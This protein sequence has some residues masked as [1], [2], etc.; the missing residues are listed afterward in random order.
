MKIAEKLNLN[1]EIAYVPVAK[2]KYVKKMMSDWKFNN[3]N[4][5]IYSF[6][7]MVTSFI[8]AVYF[9][10]EEEQ[11][12]MRISFLTSL[13]FLLTGILVTKS[14]KVLYYLPMLGLVTFSLVPAY[15]PMGTIRIFFMITVLL[16]SVVCAFYCY[17]ALYN[18]KNVYLPLS[19]RQGFPNFVLS[20]ADMYSD[21]MYEKN[22]DD[23][24]VAEKRVEA[25]YNPFSE[26]SDITDEEVARMN[27]LRYEEVKHYVKDVFRG[28]YYESKEVQYS[29]NEEKTYKYGKKI[30]CKDFIIP[31][32]EIEGAKK[33]DNRKVMWYWNE[34]KKSMFQ[35]EVIWLFLFAASIMAYAWTV[36]ELKGLLMYVFLALH[37]LGTSLV[38]KED[39]RGFPLVL[40]IYLNAT[41]DTFMS[42]I[43]VVLFTIIKIPGYIRWLCN[44]K[45]YRKLEK[46]PGFPSFVENTAD[47]YG[48]Q[49]YIVEKQEPP[50]K[51]PKMEPIIMNVGYDEEE[52]KDK[53]WNAFDYLDKDKDNSAYDD[54]EY[55]EQ[56]YE[57]RRKAEVRENQKPNKDMGR[58]TNNED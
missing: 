22:K 52:K 18:Y 57:A 17:K 1:M 27:S 24:T 9:M 20:T 29:V 48:E 15:F 2:L 55:Y 33:E 50:K 36:G 47:V 34:M 16:P 28:P 45:I 6:I 35:N 19:K 58:K 30:F 3:K 4:I 49:M 44:M 41:I 53:G 51:L 23:K 11:L 54:F 7:T 21:K 14:V 37:I 25:S 40:C 13:M 31:H 46:E 26:Q 10:Y 43:V 32:N 38:K 12:C 39:V 56:V 42:L 5:R 8:S